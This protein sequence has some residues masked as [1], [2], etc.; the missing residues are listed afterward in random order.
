M[1]TKTDFVCPV[2]RLPMVSTTSALFDFLMASSVSQLVT[3]ISSMTRSYRQLICIF[4]RLSRGPGRPSVA[5][6]ARLDRPPRRAFN[7]KDKS[8]EERPM[9]WDQFTVM[10]QEAIQKAQARAEETGRQEVRPEHLLWS[11]LAQD[12]NIVNAVLAKIGAPAAKIRADVEA[13]LERLPKVSGEARPAC[14][15]PCARSS[16]R[17][18]RKPTPSRTS[19]SRPSTSSWP[20]SRTRRARLRA[21]CAR[22]A[23]TRTRSSRPW[24]RS[25]APSA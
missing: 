17:A 25:A 18:A 6:G 14:R 13:A 9:R 2:C 12:E 3:S 11:F 8:R 24:P 7:R 1:T 22:T 10:S 16:T 21:S 20:C 4:R 19:T 15:P 5:P 23:S